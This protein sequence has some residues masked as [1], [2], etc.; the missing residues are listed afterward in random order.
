MTQFIRTTFPRFLPYMDMEKATP[1][2]GL[3]PYTCDG[4]PLLGRT[5]LKNLFLNTGHGHLG[6]SM[7]MGS[8][9][10]VADLMSDV[11]PDL[12]IT[13]YQLARFL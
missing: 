4:M 3:R 7:A 12:D 5:P 6:W 11:D 8:G 10:L 2:A 9:K 1:W 13:P